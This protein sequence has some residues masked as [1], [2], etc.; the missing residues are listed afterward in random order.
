M[1]TRREQS[2]ASTLDP[3]SFERTLDI[4]LALEDEATIMQEVVHLKAVSIVAQVLGSRPSKGDIWH[5]LLASLQA[6]L[7]KS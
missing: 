3:I 5:L 7:D 1:S 4:S 6:N 2:G